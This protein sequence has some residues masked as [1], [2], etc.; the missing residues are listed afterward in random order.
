MGMELSI[1]RIMQQKQIC[2]AHKAIN[3]ENNASK[4]GFGPR[5]PKIHDGMG[6]NQQDVLDNS[7]LRPIIFVSKRLSTAKIGYS[8]IDREALAIFHVLNKCHQMSPLLFW[9]SRYSYN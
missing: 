3:I 7:R 6:D 5:L 2:N 4:V 1:S 9:K 8:N